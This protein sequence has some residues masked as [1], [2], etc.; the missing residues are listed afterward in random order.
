MNASDL[1]R[2]IQLRYLNLAL[3]CHKIAQEHSLAAMESS[4]AWLEGVAKEVAARGLAV[5]EGPYGRA[6]FETLL[7]FE[8]RIM[9]GAEEPLGSRLQEWRKLV[10]LAHDR[11]VVDGEEFA[12]KS[13][14]AAA[15]SAIG[16]GQ[17]AMDVFTHGTS[18]DRKAVTAAASLML[19]AITRAE[20]VE[21]PIRMQAESLLRFTQQDPKRSW[22]YVALEPLGQTSDGHKSVLRCVRD[23]SAHAQ[24]RLVQEGDDWAIEFNN[25]QAP[26][27]RRFTR[28]EFE[29]FTDSHYLLFQLVLAL[30]D[31]HE[32]RVIVAAAAA[33]LTPSD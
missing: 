29:H 8:E 24:Y 3:F 6:H 25:A 7:D 33:G 20:T 12:V 11:G 15:K 28:A 13:E 18:K 16:R 23:A 4:S 9:R 21:Y 32:L 10:L 27:V 1:A 31:V 22:E 17:A 2:V 5:F 19:I 30:L 26:F 14:I